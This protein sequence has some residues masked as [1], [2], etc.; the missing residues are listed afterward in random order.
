[1]SVVDVLNESDATESGLSVSAVL[2]LPDRLR[3]SSTKQ[4]SRTTV[5]ER[6]RQQQIQIQAVAS[7]N[8]S[9]TAGMGNWQPFSAS[10]NPSAS[11]ANIAIGGS[12]DDLPHPLVE[13]LA[14]LLDDE[15]LVLILLR[16]DISDA[17]C[18]QYCLCF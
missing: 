16:C 13:Q 15:S 8:Y 18:L 17:A 7:P 14:M 11:A 4:R 2:P 1:M 3:P 6:L 10:P 9:A 12:S 5:A